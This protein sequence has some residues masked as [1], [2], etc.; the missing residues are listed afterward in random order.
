[1]LS[2]QLIMSLYLL[3]GMLGYSRS[4]VMIS[5]AGLPGMRPAGLSM[6]FIALLSGVAIMGLTSPSLD[7][8]VF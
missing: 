3:A 2:E 1:M 7:A 5:K 4:Y 8:K 6:L